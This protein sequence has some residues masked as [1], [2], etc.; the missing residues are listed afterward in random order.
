M[1]LLINII[2]AIILLNSSLLFAEI[3]TIGTEKLKK[4]I[5]DGVT[6]IDI[7]TEQEWIDTGVIKGSSLITFFDKNGNSNAEEWISRLQKIATKTDPVII[8]CRSGRRSNIV[9]N[10][11]DKKKDYL[12]VYDAT[13][14]M[15]S[16]INAK[17]IIVKPKLGG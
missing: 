8:I 15:K 5:N 14:G 10:Y 13:E 16:W 2:I 3:H 7:R 17:N 4:L 12:T 11:L 6:L 9:A 1:K